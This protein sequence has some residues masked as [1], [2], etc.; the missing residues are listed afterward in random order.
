MSQKHTMIYVEKTFLILLVILIAAC[1]STP[2]PRLSSFENSVVNAKIFQSKN[3]KTFARDENYVVVITQPGDT[4][5]SLAEKYLGD[6][7]KTWI[8]ADFNDIN[9]VVPKREIVIPLKPQNPTGI[10]PDGYQTIPILCYHRFGEG[11]EKMAI[12]AKN[13][14]EQMQYLKDNDFHVI[15]MKD[16]YDFVNGMSSLPKKSVIITIDDGYRSTFEVAYPILKDFNF[17]AT[18]FLYTDFMGA[19]DA[20]S[21]Q[22]TSEMAESKIIDFQPHSKTHPNMSLPK[23]NESDNEYKIRIKNEIDSPTEKIEKYIKTPL[24]TFAYPYGDTN[25]MIIEYLKKIK[26]KLGVTVQP[27]GNATF[28]HPYMLHRTM[29]FGDHTIADFE[30]SLVTFKQ[31]DLK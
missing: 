31:V 24:H 25:E 14:R 23:I 4:L 28:A 21:W 17:P 8:I 12:S 11:Y 5:E 10:Y 16:I 18:V 26:Y 6:A 9:E 13:F 27:G 22:Q 7:N 15:A 29:I 19:G 2:K 20:L 1:S 3:T 30:K